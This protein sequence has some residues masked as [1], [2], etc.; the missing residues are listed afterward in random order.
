MKGE[1]M[2][3]FETAC[4]YC[5]ANLK[6][7]VEQISAGT[8]PSLANG[9]WTYRKK[10]TRVCE[11][12]DS[13][14]KK[15]CAIGER[16]YSHVPLNGKEANVIWK[17]FKQFSEVHGLHKIERL[18][19]NEKE[20]GRYDFRAENT[21]TNDIFSCSIYLPGEWNS[22]KI[23]LSLFIGPRYRNVDLLD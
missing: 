1:G 21:S 23:S 13:G 20:L 7:F 11:S 22:P 17:I 18:R 14:K 12:D 4:E 10:K 19:N 6:E 2:D 3:S 16:Y 15:R 9:Q 5:G 8:I